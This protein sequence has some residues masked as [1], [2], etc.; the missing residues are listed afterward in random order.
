MLGGFRWHDNETN[1]CENLSK[2]SKA[3]KEQVRDRNLLSKLAS[4][5][6]DL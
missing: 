1:F 6:K 2:F 4:P 5:E 3:E